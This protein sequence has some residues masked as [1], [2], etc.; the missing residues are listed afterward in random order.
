MLDLADVVARGCGL[1]PGAASTL[2]LAFVRTTDPTFLVFD[3]D[4][5]YPKY[6]AK[7]GAPEALEHRRALAARLYALLPDAIAR[8][9]GVLPLEAGRALL[10]VDGLP[11]LPWFRLPA[12]MQSPRDWTSLRERCVEQLRR[13]Q[14]AV[15]SQPEWVVTAA[16]FGQ[17]LRALAASLADVL[18]PV[19][20]A[21]QAAIED[22]A[23][24]LDKLGPVPATWQHGDFV[25]NNLLVDDGRLG[26]LDLDDFGRR[27]VPL[28]DACALAC[29][30]HLQASRHGAWHDLT[31]DLAACMAGAPDA[32]T[33]TPKQK[34]AFFAY[35]LLAAIADTVGR[36]AR[37]AIRLTYLDH[38]RDLAGDSA[39]YERALA[40]QARR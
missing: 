15:A 7:V 6:V 32:A 12:R 33:F 17:S 28:L 11:G 29:S 8:P 21:G 35:F 13:F 25:L 9:L 27:H 20:P 14:E 16:A 2:T 4:Q 36:P 37:A 5:S 18:A 23:V 10:I 40:V 31:A 34:T 19:G 38:L 26:V 22:A 30:I 1:P 3:A 39:R 24:V